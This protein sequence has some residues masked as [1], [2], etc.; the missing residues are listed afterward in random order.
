VRQYAVGRSGAASLIYIVVVA[1]PL[2]TRKCFIVTNETLFS[3]P[4]HCHV[5]GSHA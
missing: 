1:F 5:T 3:T 2:L 4:Y